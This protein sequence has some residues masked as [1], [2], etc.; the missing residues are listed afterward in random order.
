VR[1]LTNKPEASP[2]D[3]SDARAQ[4]QAELLHARELQASGHEA[5]L[6]ARD[7]EAMRLLALK[8]EIAPFIEQTPELKPFIE[9]ALVAGETPRLW[10][11]LVSYVVMSPDQ[12][13]WRLVQ[14]TPEGRQVVF[15]TDQLDE[16]VSFLKKFLAHRAVMRQRLMNATP[17]PD[18]KALLRSTSAGV[19]QTW[20]WMAWLAGLATGI[21]LLLAWLMSTGKL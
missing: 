10:L 7:I 3:S 9:L 18:T 6:A 17:S 1:E 5:R 2:T 12:Q 14:D 21:F 13:H 20:L 4:M 8:Q 19:Q 11:D 16:M 15:E